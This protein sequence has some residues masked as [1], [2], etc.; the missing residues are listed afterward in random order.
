VRLA[1]KWKAE[2]KIRLSPDNRK[3]KKAVSKIRQAGFG[4]QKN[5]QKHER[6]DSA[7]SLK[8]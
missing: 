3:R 4:K 8:K 2:E 7:K 1:D 6:V 5:R